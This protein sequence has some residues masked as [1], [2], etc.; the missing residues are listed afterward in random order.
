MEHEWIIPT[1]A[2][3]MLILWIAYIARWIKR[4]RNFFAEMDVQTKRINCKSIKPEDVA[5]EYRDHYY[6]KMLDS[7]ENYK[8]IIT[9]H[10]LN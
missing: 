3:I 10:Q 5:R 9:V 1:V 7:D 6:K 2:V 8:V 4:E